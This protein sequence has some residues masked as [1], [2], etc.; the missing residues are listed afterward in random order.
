MLVVSDQ[1]GRSRPHICMTRHAALWSRVVLIQLPPVSCYG[2]RGGLEAAQEGMCQSI[3]SDASRQD[4]HQYDSSPL[5]GGR[6]SQ[7]LTM[8][9]T[10]DKHTTHTGAWDSVE[11]K[12]HLSEHI[13]RLQVTMKNALGVQASE[14][15]RYVAQ[16]SQ[17]VIHAHTCLQ[18]LH[19]AT[20][21]GDHLLLV[22]CMHGFFAC[23][24]KQV[25]ESHV[26]LLQNK[27]LHTAC[28]RSQLFRC[29]G[30]LM[31][32]ERIGAA[33]EPTDRPRSW[34][35]GRPDEHKRTHA[36]LTYDNNFIISQI[37]L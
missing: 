10:S 13:G 14:P 5:Y 7:Q 17:H 15:K 30:S 18:L 24:V 31:L 26:V 28:A 22:H 11:L 32:W 4:S 33:T 23:W 25:V 6:P 19:A 29:W 3:S 27:S 9:N 37:Y 16:N 12:A 35:D 36:A 1:L 8:C 2:R 21:A 34:P 20:V